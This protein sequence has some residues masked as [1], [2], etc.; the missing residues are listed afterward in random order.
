M[1]DFKDPAI[2]SYAVY[3]VWLVGLSPT[4]GVRQ[5][6]HVAEGGVKGNLKH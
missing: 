3:N 2:L 1:L 4:V 6:T 5:F